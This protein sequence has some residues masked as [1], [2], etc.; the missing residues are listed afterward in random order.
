LKQTTE[1]EPCAVTVPTS[2]KLH[3]MLLTQN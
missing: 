2:P 3:P 1:N